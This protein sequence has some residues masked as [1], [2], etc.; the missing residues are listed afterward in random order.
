MSV[1]TDPLAQSARSRVFAALGSLYLI[2]GSTFLA[3]RVALEGFPPLLLTGLRFLCAGSVLYCV[4]RLRGHARPTLLQWRSSL[5]VGAL[6]VSSNACV[7]VAEQ[8]VSSGVAAVAIASVPLWVALFAGLWDRWPTRKEWIGLGI[9]LVGV[10]LLQ[11]GGELSASPAGAAVLTAATVAWALGSIWSRRLPLPEGLMASAAQM[12]AGG[13]VLFIASLARG[14][15]FSAVPGWRALAAFAYLVTFGSLIGYSA[16]SYLLG[17]VRPAL[18]TSYAYVNPIVAV[19]LGAGLAHE[20]VAPG[21][22]GALALI[23]GGV[24]LL[25]FQRSSA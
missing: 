22:L 18:A 16:Y 23:L 3:I 10:A 17:K 14:E 20:A 21:A 4:L 15:R 13:A 5:L 12:A 7:V 24:G 25:A 8:W 1:P 9:G 2:W 11:W 6:L 19:G